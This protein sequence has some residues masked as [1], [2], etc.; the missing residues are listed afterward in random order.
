[1]LSHKFE[2]SARH[3]VNAPPTSSR[4]EGC[5]PIAAVCELPLRHA[6]QRAT[7]TTAPGSHAS[8]GE[9]LTLIPLKQALRARTVE[10]QRALQL[11]TASAPSSTPPA[12]TPRPA[13]SAGGRGCI[14]SLRDRAP[15]ITIENRLRRQR[16]VAARSL[17]LGLGLA[18]GGK[19]LVC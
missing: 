5:A 12:T 1:M 2:K 10:R 8:S 17:G 14:T 13:A 16:Q 19:S 11:L 4:I 9:Q 7:T 6:S 18:H 3:R 15:A